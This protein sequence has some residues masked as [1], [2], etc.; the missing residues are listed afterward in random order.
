MLFK[1]KKIA[2]IGGGLVGSLLSKYLANKGAKVCIYE[3]RNDMREQDIDAGRSINLAL[4]NRGIK[5]LKEVGIDNEVLANTMP[6]FRRI[7]HST[8]GDLTNQEY[9]KR[10]SYIFS[11]QK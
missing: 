3:R 8:E 6:M 7:M 1:D 5:S 4:S 11:W 9:G 10:S 2:I